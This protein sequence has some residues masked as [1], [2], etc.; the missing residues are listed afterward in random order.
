MGEMGPGGREGRE[1]GWGWGWGRSR[2]KG[3]MWAELD[4]RF[5]TPTVLVWIHK[6]RSL[7]ERH[8]FKLLI[9]FKLIEMARRRFCYIG[10]GW[11]V[12]QGVAQGVA[13]SSSESKPFEGHFSPWFREP[14]RSMRRSG[15]AV[16]AGGHGW[17]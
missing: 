16:C 11:G 5:R 9:L 8:C 1:V 7:H 17:A 3:G 10:G 6:K 13:L 15:F 2:W 12:A 14:V 4:V